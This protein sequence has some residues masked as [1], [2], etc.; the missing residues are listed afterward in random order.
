MAASLLVAACTGDEG[1]A[2]PAGPPGENTNSGNGDGNSPEANSA[3]VVSPGSGFLGREVDVQIGFAGGT[4]TEGVAVDFGSGVKVEN[5][6]IA[7][8]TLLTAHLVIAPN[9]TVGPHDVKVGE[10]VAKGAF[11]VSPALEATE[12]QKIEQGGIG[13]YSVKNLDTYIFDTAEDAFAIEAG[14]ELLPLSAGATGAYS[15]E[16]LFVAPPLAEAGSQQL[17]AGNLDASGKPIITFFGEPGGVKVGARPATQGT[18][19]TPIV[20]ETFTAAQL[21]SKL[22]KVTT[23]ANQDSLV[24]VTMHVPADQATLLYALLWNAGG[25]RKDIAGEIRAVDDT[26]IGSFPWEAP[27][28]LTFPLPTS[29][30]P[31]K[32]FFL[33]AIDIGGEKGTKFDFAPVALTASAVEE[34]TSAHANEATAQQFTLAAAGAANL[35]KGE[36]TDAKYDWYKF[37]A[38]QG[39]VIEVSTESG[40]SLLEATIFEEGA[41]DGDEIAWGGGGGTFDVHHTPALTAG[42]YYLRVGKAYNATG[43]PVGKYTV[44]IRRVAAE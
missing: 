37:S 42:T 29:A 15:A 30:G 33:T 32:D 2:G 10:L 24:L 4:L 3:N 1:P 7:S 41:E 16:A 12:V 5:V 17:V 21:G 19:G 18:F 11:K 6:A 22:Y 34:T 35:V 26:I 13:G 27:Y 39:D 23:P 9:A 43:T 40:T 28:D 20:G 14:E 44:G 36:V 25:K 8:P 38:A 31:A